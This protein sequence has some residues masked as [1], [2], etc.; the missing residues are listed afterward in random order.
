M[1]SG[2]GGRI[3]YLNLRSNCMSIDIVIVFIFFAGPI[4][5]YSPGGRV[6]NFYWHGRQGNNHFVIPTSQ[7][8]NRPIRKKNR[9]IRKKKKSVLW[10]DSSDYVKYKYLKKKNGWPNYLVAKPWS[11]SN[12]KE[13][14]ASIKSSAVPSK[15]PLQCPCTAPLPRETF[16]QQLLLASSL[17]LQ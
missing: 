12:T 3:C 13:T 8:T 5:G 17:Y 4:R 9:P 14:P 15:I 16:H 7:P 6:N 2:F 1:Y 10:A 11:K